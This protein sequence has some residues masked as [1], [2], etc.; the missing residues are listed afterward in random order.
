MNRLIPLIALVVLVAA[1]T[2]AAIGWKFPFFGRN[3]TSQQLDA[4]KNQ[5]NSGTRVQSASQPTKTAQNNR[6][7]VQGASQPTTTAQAPDATIN[8]EASGTTGQADADQPVPAL[9]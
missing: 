4:T 1:L 9:W 8:P 3:Q 7:A 6:T 5:A 2:G